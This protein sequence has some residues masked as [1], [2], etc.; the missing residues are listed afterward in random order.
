MVCVVTGG[1][2]GIGLAAACALA[3]QGAHVVLVCR[4]PERGRAA[5]ERVA[6]V[7]GTRV[8]L[9]L[10]DLLEQRQVCDLAARL[11]SDYPRIDVLLNN[12]GAYFGLRQ[13]TRDGVERTFA[14]NHL[15][16][17]L[18]TWLLLDRLRQSSPAR[19]VNV[20]S[21]AERAGR[22]EWDNLQGERRYRGFAAYAASK[23]A[24]VLFTC[25]LT[26][27]LHG[28]GVTATCLHPGVVSTGI[29]PELPFLG[30]LRRFARSPEQGADTA[31]WLATDPSVAGVSGQC[32][33]DRRPMTTSCRSHDPELAR[34]LWEHSER[35][36][37]SAAA[38]V[39]NENGR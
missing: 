13:L 23:L 32:F 16:H 5:R 19:I 6:S 24:N 28:S 9:H 26:R 1:S 30:L 22:I 36:V 31:V 25:E 29:W 35:M 4:D 37:R 15:A 20:S 3:A 14:L 27:R 8:D 39:V 33:K 38:A 34:A 7:G 2:G 21:A 10:A 18:L 17:F 12:A 11:L